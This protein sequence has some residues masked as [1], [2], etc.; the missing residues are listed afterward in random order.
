[1][2]VQ[3]TFAYVD[4]RM[5]VYMRAHALRFAAIVD[6]LFARSIACV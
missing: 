3:G 2:S 1:M 4:V 6:G 5:H